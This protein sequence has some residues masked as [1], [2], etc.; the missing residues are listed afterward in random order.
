MR[1]HSVSLRSTTYMAKGV[2][3]SV[4]GEDRVTDRQERIPGFLQAR[5]C[6]SKIL[7]IGAGGLGG[8]IG[9]GVVR[10]GI[11]TLV[12]LDPDVVEVSNLNR[13]RFFKEDL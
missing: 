11:G 1:R 4:E 7:L 10:K 9:E 3:T 12:I 5:L 8:E 13:Q 6:G 2:T